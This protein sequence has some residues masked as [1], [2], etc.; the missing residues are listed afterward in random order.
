MA[1]EQFQER[2]GGVQRLYGVDETKKLADAHVCVVGIGGVGSWVAES[3]ARSGVG[4]LTL[5]DMD[6]IAESNTNRQIHTLGETIGK[7]KVAVMAER[8]LSI[9]PECQ[10]HP[11]EDFIAEKNMERYLTSE[12]SYVVDAIDMVRAKAAMI[13][14]CK[15]MKIPVVCIGGAGGQ[16]D[17]LRVTCADLS[18]TVQDPLAAKLR[19]ALRRFYGFSKNP[20]RRFGIECVY[21]TEQPIYPD[22]TGGTCQ[23]KPEN[24]AKT[25]LD[26]NLGFGASVCV[27]ATFANVAVSRVIAKLLR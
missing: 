22:G 18:R 20:K 7:P 26:C 4:E 27:T 9:N 19:S 21:S 24:H 2:F 5:I 8:V 16:T 25:R 15:R 12:M 11:V 1:S 23:K 14:H 17:P 13:A 3:L 10:C 6:D